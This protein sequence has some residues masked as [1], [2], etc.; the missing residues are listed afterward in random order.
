MLNYNLGGMAANAVLIDDEQPAIELQRD[1]PLTGVQAQIY[2]KRLEFGGLSGSILLGGIGL[3]VHWVV[4]KDWEQSVVENVFTSVM[5]ALLGAVIGAVYG[6]AL[7]VL[8]IRGPH[9]IRIILGAIA[10]TVIG[11]GLTVAVVQN[12]RERLDIVCVFVAALTTV[13]LSAG[14]FA[15]ESLPSDPYC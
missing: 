14:L 13:G 6:A 1:K 12:M 7:A 5:V 8:T 3:V 2:W 4:F 11:A 15:K 9:R 10:G